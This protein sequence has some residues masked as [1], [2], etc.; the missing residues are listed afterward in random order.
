MPKRPPTSDEQKAKLSLAQKFYVANDPRW[1]EHRQKLA[2]AQIAKR[3]T[4]FPNEIEA[5]KDMRKKG[6]TFDY[7][8]HEIGVCKE[9]IHRELKALGISTE[10][11]KP[12]KR[13]KRGSGPWRSFDPA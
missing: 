3:M 7:I 10:A 13:A 2:D 1:A 8:Q 4:L 9:V 11:I 5:I 6:R 12:E